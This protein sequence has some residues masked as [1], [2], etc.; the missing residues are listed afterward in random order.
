MSTA[1]HMTDERNADRI[2][3]LALVVR[4]TPF[5]RYLK[6]LQ[7][8]VLMLVRSRLDHPEIVAGICR[9]RLTILPRSISR[10]SNLA[11]FP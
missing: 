7:T 5:E 10:A 2:S 1:A 4:R 6:P 11:P 9:I 8:K 3:A